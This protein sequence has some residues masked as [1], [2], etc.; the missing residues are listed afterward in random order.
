MR[1]QDDDRDL[2]ESPFQQAWERVSMISSLERAI[3][4]LHDQ[5]PRENGSDLDWAFTLVEKQLTRKIMELKGL[6]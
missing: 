3:S 6:R 2:E 5:W 1:D 4:T